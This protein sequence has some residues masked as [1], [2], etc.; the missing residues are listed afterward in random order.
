[1]IKCLSFLGVDNSDTIQKFLP[2]AFGPANSMSGVHNNFV[3]ILSMHSYN[4]MIIY[5][6]QWLHTYYIYI[7]IY[8]YTHIYSYA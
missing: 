5:I 2:S 7:Y 3:L 1:M 8:I 6:N 4:C